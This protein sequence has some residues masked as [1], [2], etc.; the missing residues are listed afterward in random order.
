[1]TNFN[2][3]YLERTTLYTLQAYKVLKAQD[4]SAYV[5]NSLETELFYDDVECDGHCLLD[6]INAEI[7]CGITNNEESYF[8]SF[9]AE[10]L[11]KQNE[12]AYVINILDTETDNGDGYCLMEEMENYLSLNNLV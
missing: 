10:L 7:H 9:F 6:E 8:L 2:T 1:M 4:E 5:L 3:D 12:S 11:E